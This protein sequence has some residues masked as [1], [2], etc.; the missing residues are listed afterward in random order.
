MK[1]NKLL[2]GIFCVAL[3]LLCCQAGAQVKKKTTLKKKAAAPAIIPKPPFATAPEIEDGKTLI[4]KSDCLACHK[5]EEKLVG[6]AYIAIAGKYPQ[7]QASVTMLSQKIISGGSGTWGPVP[8]APHP[9]VSAD[10]A[11]KMVKYIL[12]LSTQNATAPTDKSR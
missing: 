1:I 3:T 11:N 9:A 8:M 4:A 6:P 12:T 10:E 5:V 2:T 7:D